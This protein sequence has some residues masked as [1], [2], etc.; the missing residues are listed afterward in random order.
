MSKITS[1]ACDGCGKILYGKEKAA[2]VKK[3][4]VQI[5]GQ[6][7]LQKVDSETEWSYPV[8][9]TKTKEDRLNFCDLVCLQEFIEYKEK[10]Y[11]E[12]RK[13]DLRERARVEALDRGVKGLE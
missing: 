3:A 4:N 1:I 7:V 9:I 5:N 13:E 10:R 2:F 11:E 12:F 8:Y 6:I